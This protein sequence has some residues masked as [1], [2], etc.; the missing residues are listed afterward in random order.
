VSNW[1][2]VDERLPAVGQQVIAAWGGGP[3]Q[4]AEMTYSSNQCA[5]TENGRKARF[6][7]M[8]RISPWTVTHWMPMPNHPFWCKDVEEQCDV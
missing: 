3:K 5:K 1:I 7:W 2:S 8:G 6:E 4:I